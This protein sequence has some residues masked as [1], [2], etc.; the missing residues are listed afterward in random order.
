MNSYALLTFFNF[1]AFISLFCL[2]F[3]NLSCK[4]IKL[5]N[6][7]KLKRKIALLFTS[8]SLFSLGFGESINANYD[9]IKIY[10]GKNVD[11]ISSGKGTLIYPNGEKYE[12]DIVDNMPNGKGILIYPNGDKYAGEFVDGNFQGKVTINLTNGKKIKGKWLNG[13]LVN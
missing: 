9:L 1:V 13:N 3:D 12:G 7:M 10:Q 8:I 11:N 4:L 2:N 6:L 5:F